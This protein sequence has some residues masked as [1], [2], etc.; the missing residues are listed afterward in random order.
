MIQQVKEWMRTSFEP[1][2]GNS[3]AK[4]LLIT[5]IRRVAWRQAG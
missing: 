5:P 2:F 4:P 1:G 3:V